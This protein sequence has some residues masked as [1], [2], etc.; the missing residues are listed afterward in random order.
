MVV[1]GAVRVFSVMGEIAAILCTD[2]NAPTEKD[3]KITEAM[4]E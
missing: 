2:Y 3:R 4:T 1:I